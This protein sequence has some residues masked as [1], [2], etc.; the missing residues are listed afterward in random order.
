M[1]INGDC[2]LFRINLSFSVSFSA[3]VIHS[4][5]N[6]CA[7]GAILV[8]F[9]LASRTNL[10]RELTFAFAQMLVASL[11]KYSDYAMSS[12]RHSNCSPTLTSYARVTISTW[13]TETQTNPAFLRKSPNSQL[14]MKRIRDRFSRF[15]WVKFLTA[16]PWFHLI[17][18]SKIEE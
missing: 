11:L 17:F 14:E 15:F 8:S 10:I 9:L 6:C 12:W 3:S 16:F 5:L 1:G 2:L 4:E 13:I 18:P 7:V